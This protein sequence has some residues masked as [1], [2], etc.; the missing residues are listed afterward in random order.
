[1][2]SVWD[3][4]QSD[5]SKYLGTGRTRITLGRQM[6]NYKNGYKL[7][8]KPYIFYYVVTFSSLY[9]CSWNFFCLAS[10]KPSSLYVIILSIYIV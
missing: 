9:T 2:W 8:K 1:M 5:V 7:C 3:L 4:R 10:E 6:N